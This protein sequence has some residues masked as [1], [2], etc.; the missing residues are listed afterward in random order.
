MCG[1]AHKGKEVHPCFIKILFKAFYLLFEVYVFLNFL[2][3]CKQYA[4]FCTLELPVGKT[5]VH[6]E[7]N[8]I[9]KIN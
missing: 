3:H 1:D 9:L 7:D 8:L 4:V 2:S 5:D 6:K